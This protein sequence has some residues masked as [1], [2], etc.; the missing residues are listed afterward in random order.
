MKLINRKNVAVGELNI[1]FG[2][3]TYRDPADGSER[4]S[5]T[6]YAECGYNGKRYAVPLNTDDPAL[7]M[8][9]IHELGERILAG[10][11]AKPVKL[12]IIDLARR[13]LAYQ[14]SMSRAETT[15]TKYEYVL[16]TFGAW[17]NTNFNKAVG[18]FTEGDFW[19]WHRSVSA[20]Y[21]K[22]TAYD[23]AIIIKQ[24]FKWAVNKEKLLPSNPVS[25]ATMRKPA[26]NEQPVFSPDQ[27]SKLLVAADPHF[28]PI[29]AVAAYAGL[30]FGE[31]RDLTWDMVYLP[32]D[33][34][35]HLVIRLGG[36]G[37]TTKTGR[38]RRMP[39]WFRRSHGTRFGDF[40]RRE[41]IF[42]GLSPGSLK[43]LKLR[44]NLKHQEISYA[45]AEYPCAYYFDCPPSVG[46]RV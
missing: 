25:G 22:K 31:V 34:P 23:R 17:A 46:Q 20:A 28:K 7:A 13:Y 42:A 14:T 19:N 18:K 30:R 6:F 24:M 32:G 37:D 2:H 16:A 4:V 44:R 39:P 40:F 27:I 15:L 38:V 29:L 1:Q 33:G 35:G 3:R 43:R 26:P 10:K 8:H 21:G 12:T 9:R 36:C 5:Q 45:L 41:P 11:G